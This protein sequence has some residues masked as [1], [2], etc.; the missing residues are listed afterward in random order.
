MKT[1]QRRGRVKGRIRAQL[2]GLLFLSE[3]KV[4][5]DLWTDTGGAEALW[6]AGAGAAAVART[7][8]SAQPWPEQQRRK[9]PW[10]SVGKRAGPARGLPAQPQ[11]S[12]LLPSPGGA[13]HQHKRLLTSERERAHP[14]NSWPRPGPRSESG[15]Q[16]LGRPG[17][18]AKGLG[19]GAKG[20]EGGW[21]EE[22]GRGPGVTQ[23]IRTSQMA[24]KRV[25]K[26]RQRPV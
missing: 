18:S 20:G 25:S 21:E 2:E 10:A 14:A 13:G 19:P 11:L 6:P 1:L 16:T 15:Q 23:A 24:E 7:P 3:I 8:G 17:A 4:C 26:N 9:K 22:R 5:L 12:S